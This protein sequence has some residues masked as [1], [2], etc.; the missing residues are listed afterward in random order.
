MMAGTVTCS[1][2]ATVYT[3]AAIISEMAFLFAV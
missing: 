3:V 1:T 2:M